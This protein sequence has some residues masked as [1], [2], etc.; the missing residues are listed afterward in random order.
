MLIMEFI[1]K[2][3][4]QFLLLLV[5][6]LGSCSEKEDVEITNKTPDNYEVEISLKADS[7][8][9]EEIY[10]T[11]KT[12]ELL[13][14]GSIT[15]A[16]VAVENVTGKRLKFN[17]ALDVDRFTGN[18]KSGFSQPVRVFGLNPGDQYEI[19]VDLVYSHPNITG[20]TYK[21][22]G[23]SVFPVLPKYTSS[24]IQLL[25]WEKK[26]SNRLYVEY[27]RVH[28]PKLTPLEV[29]IIW[30]QWDFDPDLYLGAPLTS[31]LPM[32]AISGTAKN[33]YHQFDNVYGTVTP[34]MKMGLYM[35][36][37]NPDLSYRDTV[38]SPEYFKIS[39][40]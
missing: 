17:F 29:G 27:S 21:S 10:F 36:V 3:R 16:S 6:F 4:F 8:L 2:S 13:F 22:S 14:G 12:S 5:L 38:Y 31:S 33:G 19:S 32:S 39:T 15:S 18:N 9:E 28:D 1:Y 23:S 24:K 11:L 7:V 26:T 30:G 40:F 25:D 35:I 34:W 20:K 37:G